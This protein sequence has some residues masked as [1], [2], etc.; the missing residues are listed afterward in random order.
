MKESDTD[1]GTVKKSD[2]IDPAVADAA[3]ALKDGEVSAPVKGRF[4]TVIVTVTKIEPEVDKSLADVA[5]QIRNDIAADRAK[6]DVQ[7]LHDKIEDD[8]AGGASLEQAAQKLKL[9]FGNFEVDRSG[10][11]PSGK[12]ATLP[13]AGQVVSAAF[14]SDV[15]VDNDPIETDGG[16]VWYAVTAHHAG[17]RSRARRGQ[18]RSR[19]ALARGRDCVAIESQSVRNSRQAQ[20][21]HA[22]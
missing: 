12:V 18:E 16:Y 19:G 6:T 2:I 14:N 10:R 20:S 9:P 1:L 21:R 3:F 13:H 22:V 17:A 5:P 7:S 15:G 11:D 4:G 8:R